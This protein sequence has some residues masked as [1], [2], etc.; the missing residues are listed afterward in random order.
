LQKIIQQNS[1]INKKV[2]ELLARQKAIEERL[3]QME[4]DHEQLNMNKEFT[5]VIKLL[6]LYYIYIILLLFT[7]KILIYL[8][9]YK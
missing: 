8:G 9:H 5:K 1:E 7:I 6:F 2:D 4:V 3:E